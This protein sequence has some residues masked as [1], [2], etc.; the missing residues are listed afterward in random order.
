MMINLVKLK[1]RRNNYS[2]LSIDRFDESITILLKLRKPFLAHSGYVVS[3]QATTSLMS[4]KGLF[5]FEVKMENLIYPNLSNYQVLLS[6]TVGKSHEKNTLVNCIIC[7]SSFLVSRN[8]I[9]TAKLRNSIAIYCSH[10]CRNLAFI[11]T[12][13]WQS[14]TEITCQEC[15]KVF[16]GYAKNSRTRGERKYCSLS[17]L[18]THRNKYESKGYTRS[19]FEIWLEK[20]LEVIFPTLNMLFND[21]KA[22]GL[23]LDIY[24]PSLSL[25]I[26]INGIYH[27]RPI[28]GE[29]AL[30]SIRRRDIKKLT[31]CKEKNISVYVVDISK[32]NTMNELEANDYLKLIE[33]KIKDVE[34]IYA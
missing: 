15:Q 17:C 24:I 16:I 23:E 3:S 11:K 20:Q 12:V 27:Y 18:A 25:A 33:E 8:R 13:G 9:M 14:K 6:Q 32:M 34:A 26:E 22:I 4:Q 7:D 28:R 21:R 29:K 2:G 31:K 30:D 5:L 10:S 19:K 1:V